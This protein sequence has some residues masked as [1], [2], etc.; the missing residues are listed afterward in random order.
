MTPRLLAAA[1][2]GWFYNEHLGRWPSRRLRLAYLRHWFAHCDAEAGVQTGC[3]FLHGRNISLGPRSVINHGCLLDGRV[4]PIRIG[5][6]VSIGPEAALLTLGHDPRSPTFADRG[7]P[8]TIGD[9]VCIGYRAIVLPGLNIG[10]G[11]VVGAGSVVT[12]DV[13]SFAIVAGNPA[14][15]IGTRPETLHYQLSYRP[16]L[17]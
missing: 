8:M 11:A 14:Q 10:N 2:V 13:P 5:A 15:V 3:R 1:L 16:F 7:G 4:H 12:R 9:H 6:D 17:L